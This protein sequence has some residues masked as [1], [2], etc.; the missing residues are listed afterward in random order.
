MK[1]SDHTLLCAALAISML[2]LYIN[3]RMA[4]GLSQ[5]KADADKTIGGLKASIPSP[6]LSFL[7][8]A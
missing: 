1:L 5:L 3:Y 8:L 2:S 4:I 7:G 6:V